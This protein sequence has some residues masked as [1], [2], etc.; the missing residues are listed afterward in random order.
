MRNRTAF[1]QAQHPSN[2][3]KIHF[4]NVGIVPSFLG[5]AES[6]IENTSFTV[7][8]VPRDREIMVRS[9]D[10]RIVFIIE[11]RGVETEQ[12]V[13]FYAR[14]I[15]RLV[16]LVILDEGSGKVTDRQPV[17]SGRP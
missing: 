17:D 9:V 1:C 16:D 13:D 12:D 3:L 6:R 14:P 8:L 10:A 5:V 11:F 4:A 15:F 7:Q 2:R